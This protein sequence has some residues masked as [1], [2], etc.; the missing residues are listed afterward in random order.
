M[1][2]SLIHTS[3]RLVKVDCLKKNALLYPCGGVAQTPTFFAGW[4]N[5][6]GD[7]LRGMKKKSFIFYRMRNGEAQQR[8][9][10]RRER[11]GIGCGRK[12]LRERCGGWCGF[13]WA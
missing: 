1:I 5:G 11:V 13:S 12:E 2:S 7:L 3:W 10:N 8:W 6:I 4:R 9:S